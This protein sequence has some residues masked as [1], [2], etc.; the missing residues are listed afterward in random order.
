MKTFLFLLLLVPTTFFVGDPVVEWMVPKEHDFGDLQQ[1]QPVDYYFKFK[2]VSNEP[3]V[4]DN[5]RTTCG[6]TAPNWSKEPV[7]SDSTSQIKITYDARKTGYFRKKIRVFFSNQRKGEI[8]F[9]E[10]FVLD[11]ED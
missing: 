1:G 9:I 10:G 7:E 5:I 4:I 3:F 8:L 2:N 6:C 11:P